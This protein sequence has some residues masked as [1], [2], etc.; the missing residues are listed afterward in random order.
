[1]PDAVRHLAVDYGLKRV[2]LALSDAGGSLASPLAVLQVASPEHAV[3]EVAK[4]AEREGPDLLVVGLP[5]D[6]SGVEGGSAKA[7]REW[8]ATLVAATGVPAILVD[9]RLSSFAAES[10]LAARRQGGEKLTRGKKKARLDAIAAATFLQA[11]FDGNVQAMG[12]IKP[13]AS[14][15]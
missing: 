11:Y 14:A 8:T 2:G 9:E 13:D 12:R 10:D 7:V 1:M 3:R 15:D 4:V 6:M 5:I